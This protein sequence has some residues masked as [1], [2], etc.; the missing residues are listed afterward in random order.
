LH[1]ANFHEGPTTQTQSNACQADGSPVVLLDCPD[2]SRLLDGPGMERK[3]T[4]SGNITAEIKGGNLVITVPMNP[5][6]VNSASGKTKVVASTHGNQA[7]A[8][9]VEGKPVI[10]GVNA[11]IK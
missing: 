3:N 10:I 5:V 9:L 8:L 2:E 11:Y 1:D 7:T 6:P 4:M